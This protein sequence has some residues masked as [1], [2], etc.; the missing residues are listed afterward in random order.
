MGDLIK[1]LKGSVSE[2]RKVTW[3]TKDEVVRATV[4]TIIF[5]TL[6]AL[7]LFGVDVV[8]R[9]VLQGLMNG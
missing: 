1:F 4:A 8:A 9:I 7:I 2:L 5:I 3:P 6:F